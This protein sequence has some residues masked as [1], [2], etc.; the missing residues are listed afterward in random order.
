MEIRNHIYDFSLNPKS[1]GTKI[2]A[3]RKS[4]KMTAEKLAEALNHSVKTISSWETGSRFPSLDALVDL[5]NFF[6]VSVHSLTLP[7]DNCPVS[8]L[9]RHSKEL[10]LLNPPYYIGDTSDEI[11]TTLLIREEYLIQRMLCGVF[12]NQNKCEYDNISLALKHPFDPQGNEHKSENS[13]ASFWQ[14]KKEHF[15]ISPRKPILFNRILRGECLDNAL[16]ALDLFDRSVF[17]TMLCYFPEFRNWDCTKML[18]ENGARFIDCQFHE[19]NTQIER[20]V[21]EKEKENLF[22]ITIHTISSEEEC[23]LFWNG[24]SHMS[25]EQAN[26][27]FSFL[28][29]PRYKDNP[30]YYNGKIFRKVDVSHTGTEEQ[31]HKLLARYYSLFDF[32]ADTVTSLDD[33]CKRR[34]EK[35]MYFDP[36]IKNLLDRGIIT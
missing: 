18:Y 11:I 17:F 34:I 20:A 27:W 22:N 4:K 7:L 33:F 3:L 25:E 36:Y 1:T 6:E 21:E 2:K 24:G 9:P 26:D 10:I 14:F 30:D 23:Q 31:E 16:C 19:R 35:H 8:P 13:A 15:Y 29:V 28:E 5:A 32:I 12:T